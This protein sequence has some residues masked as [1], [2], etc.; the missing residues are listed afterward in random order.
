MHHQIN[1]SSESNK[2]VLYSYLLQ[3]LL[4]RLITQLSGISSIKLVD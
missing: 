3:Q 2:L 4:G 1:N